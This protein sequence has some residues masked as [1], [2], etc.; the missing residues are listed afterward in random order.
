MQIETLYFKWASV[1]LSQHRPRLDLMRLLRD[2]EGWGWVVA[3]RI[4]SAPWRWNSSFSWILE[5]FIRIMNIRK[6]ISRVIHRFQFHWSIN[7]H[8][9]HKVESYSGEEKIGSWGL[10]IPSKIRRKPLHRLDGSLDNKSWHWTTWMDLS[11]QRLYLWF[12][13]LMLQGHICPIR[14]EDTM[15]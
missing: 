5:H 13:F 3:D 14:P 4:Y 12:Y 7:Q 11:S 9:A 8:W 2:V 1:I 6:W 15:F 10:F